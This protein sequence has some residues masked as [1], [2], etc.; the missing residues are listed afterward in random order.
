MNIEIL[1]AQSLRNSLLATTFYSTSSATIL[2]L[3]LALL[4]DEFSSTFSNT[5]RT[6]Q[7]TVLSGFLGLSILNFVY[8]M[9]LY[10]SV[11]FLVNQ[12]ISEQVETVFKTYKKNQKARKR[13]TR[14]SSNSNLVELTNLQQSDDL[15]VSS[16]K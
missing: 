15:E 1:A 9:R 5:L 14:S 6:V 10:V 7:F 2:A 11:G 13:N 8:S 12:K 4:F 3:I 16:R